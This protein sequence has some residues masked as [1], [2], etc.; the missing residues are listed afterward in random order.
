MSDKNGTPTFESKVNET[1]ANTTKDDAGKLVLPEG[2]DEATAFATRAEIRRRDT[3]AAFTKGQQRTKALE[4]ENEK[5]A[6]S[7][8]SDAVS[9]LS[10]TEQAKLEE[11]KVQDPEAWRAEI[12]N[13]EE[14]KRTKFK[15]KR[16]EITKE[17]SQMTELERRAAQLEQFNTDNPN[18]VITDD[19]IQND[20][21]PRITK[22]L[23]AGEIQFDE[24]LE[25]VK[26][27]LGKN[28]VIDKGEGAPNEPDFK[29]AR[30]GGNP[31]K[32]AVEKQNSNDY[33][34]EIF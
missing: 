30:G 18:L 2:I 23:E 27:Y 16:A 7:W 20:I 28:K 26:T 14:G 15:E 22:K 12:S 31:T 3:Q 19:V 33:T 11:L 25:E 4:A 32:E 34:K 24:Y 6:A 29:N 21:P 8:E 1:I 13:L 5:L 9:N 10:S 17:A